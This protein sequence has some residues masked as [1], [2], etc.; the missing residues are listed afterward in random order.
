MKAGF[1]RLAFAEPMSNTHDNHQPPPFPYCS[2][3]SSPAYYV[4]QSDWG[5]LVCALA[6]VVGILLS[7]LM[8]AVIN[9]ALTLKEHQRFATEYAAGRGG[10]RWPTVPLPPS[11]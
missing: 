4:T 1:V 11:L 6:S 7:S 5:R 10:T 8:V 2:T 9:Q 3:Q